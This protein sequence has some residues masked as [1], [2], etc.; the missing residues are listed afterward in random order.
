[1]GKLREEEAEKGEPATKRRREYTDL[2]LD[3]GEREDQAKS[4]AMPQ[5]GFGDDRR[6]T[7]GSGDVSLTVFITSMSSSHSLASFINRSFHSSRPPGFRM[8]FDAAERNEKLSRI[9][10]QRSKEGSSRGKRKRRIF[11]CR[12]PIRFKVIPTSFLKI[13]ER[14]KFAGAKDRGKRNG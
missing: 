3:L 13:E 6:T 8:A 11:L 1:M 2:G 10:C 14:G 5:P 9:H 7:S 12:R 4:T